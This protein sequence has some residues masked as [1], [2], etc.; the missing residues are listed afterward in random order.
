MEEKKKFQGFLILNQEKKEYTQKEDF[1]LHIL[2][3]FLP[4]VKEKIQI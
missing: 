4:Q 3:G 1:L 2:Q